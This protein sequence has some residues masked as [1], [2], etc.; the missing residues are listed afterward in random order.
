MRSGIWN[1]ASMLGALQLGQARFD[2][3]NWRKKISL[4]MRRYVLYPACAALAFVPVYFFKQLPSNVF[5]Q[6]GEIL[7]SL[8]GVFVVTVLGVLAAQFLF[9]RALTAKVLRTL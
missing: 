9:F 2:L 4:P 5:E 8:Q 3:V 7:W 1:G 6:I